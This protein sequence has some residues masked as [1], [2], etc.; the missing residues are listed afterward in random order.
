MQ[1]DLIPPMRHVAVLTLLLLVC[2]SGRF[3]QGQEGAGWTAQLGAGVS[4]PVGRT[5]D[6][7]H[8]SGSFTAGLGY[9]LTG[10]QTVLLEYYAAGLPFNS[11][12]LDQL[13]FLNPTSDLYSVT[14]NY[15]FEFLTSATTRP[16]LIGG[17]GWYRR[18]SAITTPSGVTAIACSPWLI[19]W[20][21][22]CVA[23]TVPLE[24]IVASSNS[25][26]LGFNIGAGFSRRIRKSGAHW[27]VEVRYHYAPHQGVP[28]ATLPVI[29][30]LAFF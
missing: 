20:H 25:D 7:A 6:F 5:A 8:L 4:I 29:V 13:R 23:G 3:L 2:G 12:L 21:Y 1:L 16:Y 11:S 17:G 14:A 26:A 18:V 24:K 22:A 27:Y 10:D 28:T 30:G 9:H 19:W 15:K